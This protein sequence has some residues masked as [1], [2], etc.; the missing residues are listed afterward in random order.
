M[1][2]LTNTLLA[3]LLSA[4]VFAVEIPNQFEDGQVTSASQMNENFQALKAE[5]EALKSQLDASTE[6]NKVTFVGVTEEKFAGNGG[7]IAIGKACDAMVK[8]SVICTKDMYRKS[9]KPEEVEI[10]GFGWLLEESSSNGC[11]DFTYNANGTTNLGIN[12][13]GNVSFG[14]CMNMHGI[15]C[16]K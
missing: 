11:R 14:N 13:Y 5:I 3:L 6:S 12:S 7:L 1:K 15:A 10:N 4:N 8:N 9:I 16:C 2:S